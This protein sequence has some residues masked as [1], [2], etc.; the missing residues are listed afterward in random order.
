[1]I[2]IQTAA[3]KAKIQSKSCTFHLRLEKGRTSREFTE[4]P[5][6]DIEDLV[7]IG[8]KLK[9]CPFFVS[10]DQVENADIVF[11]PY[12]YL[13]DPKVRSSNNVSR[14]N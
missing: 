10:K 9:V 5:I 8:E 1:M 6:L 3:C 4:P 13:L 11:M 14:I 2:D 12:N 7:K